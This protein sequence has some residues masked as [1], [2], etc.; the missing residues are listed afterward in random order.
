MYQWSQNPQEHSNNF[1]KYLKR[2]I[3]VVNDEEI[4]KVLRFTKAN[5]D[6]RFN[7]NKIT[8]QWESMMKELLEKYPTEE[9]RKFPE[10]LFVYRT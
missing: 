8:A 3:S 5:A 7:S 2:A 9:S 6:M 10:E 4:S 1:Y